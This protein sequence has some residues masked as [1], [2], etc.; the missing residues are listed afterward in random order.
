MGFSLGGIVGGALKAVGLSKVAPFVS[1][2]VNALTGNWAAAAVDAAGILSKIKGL[3]FLKNVAALAPLG[4]FGK[5]GFVI[6]K[7]FGKGGLNFSRLG[8]LRS[9]VGVA[10]N[11]T[12]GKLTK[13]S[14]ALDL[15][16]RTVQTAGTLRQTVNDARLLGTR[17]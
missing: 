2:G 14:A 6:G 5:G 10:N 3:G 7:L 13:F 1:A 9:L 4:G 12:G 16:E 15:I 17:A 8:D 11:V